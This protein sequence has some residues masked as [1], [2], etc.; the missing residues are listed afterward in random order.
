MYHELRGLVNLRGAELTQAFASIPA[1]VTSLNLGDNDLGNKTVAELAEAFASIPATVTSLD[2]GFNNL[3]NKTVA[4]LAQAF[5]GIPAT[6]TSLGLGANNLR[7][8]TGA[9]LA[10][11]FASIPATVTS[12]GLG[13]NNLRNK[14]GAEQINILLSLPA[15]IISVNLNGK[16]LSPAEHVLAIIFP[17]HM[18]HIYHDNN[19]FCSP[20]VIESDVDINNDMLIKL[21]NFFQAHPTPMNCLVCALLLEG[22]ILNAYTN[23]DTNY[24][25]RT[26]AA[27]AFYRK[28]ACDEAL[29]PMIKGL[30]WHK[31]VIEVNPVVL[32][33]LDQYK[34]EPKAESYPFFSDASERQK[35]KHR[36]LLDI[37]DTSVT[38]LP[39]ISEQYLKQERMLGSKNRSGDPMEFGVNRH[40]RG[41]P[42]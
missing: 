23:D 39:I 20:D 15:S 2:L 4:E 21:V 17:N 25:N 7:N 16:F 41:N 40:D 19:I 34:L 37:A 13:S 3:G 33:E 8:K 11:A 36:P 1:T 9:E 12:L 38:P 28:A 29:K 35:N 5:A 10:Q 42:R 18:N 27:I 31:R 26:L 14:T 22:K 30:L 32:Y 24:T 6:V